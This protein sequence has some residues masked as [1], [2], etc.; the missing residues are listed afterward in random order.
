[1]SCFYNGEIEKIKEVLKEENIIV[2]KAAN[3]TIVGLYISPA[4]KVDD[5]VEQIAKALTNVENEENVII[6]GDL[7]CRLDKPNSKMDIIMELLLA[8]G[9][10]LINR[11]EEITYIAPNGSSII[12][13]IFYRG[14]DIKLMCHQVAKQHSVAVLKKHLPVYAA[15]RIGKNQP[16]QKRQPQ[17]RTRKLDLDKLQADKRRL[18]ETSQLIEDGQIDLTYKPS[19]T[20]SS[21]P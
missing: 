11:K 17:P 9:Y 13:L 7:N 4:R 3:I 6:A 1:M 16:H 18:N 12:D 14:K 15:F 19:T 21:M 20:A 5:A 10:D 2:I 8:E